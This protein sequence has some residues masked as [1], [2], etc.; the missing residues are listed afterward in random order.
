MTI[1]DRLT[2]NLGLRWESSEAWLPEQSRGGGRWFPV[3]TFPETH[4][5]INFSNLSPRVGLV[6]ALG[7]ERRT[8]IR[9]V[10]GDTTR[11]SSPRTSPSPYPLSEE[12]KRTNGTT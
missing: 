9:S 11:R 8:S 3:S 7:E 6:Y 5:L 4:D 1:G 12:A 10:T 2:L